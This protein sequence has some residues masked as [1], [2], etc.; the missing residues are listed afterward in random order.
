MKPFVIEYRH[1]GK[2]YHMALEAES[3]EDAKRRMNSAYFNG[4][5]LE[6]VASVTVPKWMA[7]IW[8]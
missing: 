6:R 1:M 8:G 7:E 3:H 5:P 4:E 2:T